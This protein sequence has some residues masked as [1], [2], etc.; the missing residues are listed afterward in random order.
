MKKPI[1]PKCNSKN[2]CSIV[3]GYPADIEVYLEAV[4]KKELYPGG[5]VV[6]ENSPDWFCNNC[7]LMWGKRNDE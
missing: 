4:A 2:T 1:C 6:D 5:C 3:Y 7:E